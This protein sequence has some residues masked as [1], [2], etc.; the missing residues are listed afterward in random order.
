MV[1]SFVLRRGFV[2]AAL[3]LVLVGGAC[4]SAAPADAGTVSCSVKGLSGYNLWLKADAHGLN[5]T[6]CSVA[7]KAWFAPGLDAVSARVLATGKALRAGMANKSL[8]P[9]SAT[10]PLVSLPAFTASG[11]RSVLTP[12]IMGSWK[13]GTAGKGTFCVYERTFTQWTNPN[14]SIDGPTLVQMYTVWMDQTMSTPKRT[15]VV[16][17]WFESNTFY[18]NY[19]YKFMNSSHEGEFPCGK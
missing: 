17:Y 10:S 9:T 3:S 13:S 15:H 5:G 14:V 18:N 19:S 7:A 4:V 2:A 1:S 16:D 6:R 8:S 11:K 12:Q